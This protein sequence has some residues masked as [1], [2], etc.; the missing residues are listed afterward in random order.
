MEGPATKRPRRIQRQEPPGKRG[1]AEDAAILPENKRSRRDASFVAEALLASGCEI[2]DGRV[3]QILRSWKF[4]GNVTRANVTPRESAFVL[5]DTLGL[6][7]TRNGKV[8]PSRL[9]K[10]WPAV[11][12]VFSSWARQASVSYTHLTLPTNRE[13]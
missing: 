9:T 4:S 2:T 12:K 6:V 11:F 8:T 5:S 13:V 7:C 10:R 3:L 1:L